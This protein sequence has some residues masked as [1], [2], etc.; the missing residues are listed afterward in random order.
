MIKIGNALLLEQKELT[1]IIEQA[2]SIALQR[3]DEKR[4]ED[5]KGFINMYHPTLQAA[6]FLGISTDHLNRLT[7]EGKLEYVPGKPNKYWGKILVEFK[8]NK[9][10]E[11]DYIKTDSKKHLTSLTYNRNNVNR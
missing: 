11:A 1:E 4:E 5:A 9:I 3:H 10:Q 2:V 6:E 8:K 7:S